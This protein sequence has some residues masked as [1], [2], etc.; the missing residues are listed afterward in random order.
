MSRQSFGH[1]GEHCGQILA[2]RSGLSEVCSP[3]RYL[4]A[5]RLIRQQ[6]RAAK[7]GPSAG[8]RGKEGGGGAEQGGESVRFVVGEQ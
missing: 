5:V 4:L 1:S 8:G 3:R 6:W 7:R 2:A